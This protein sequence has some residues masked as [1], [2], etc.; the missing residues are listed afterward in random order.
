MVDITNLEN[1]DKETKLNRLRV[2]IF[3]ASVIVAVVLVVSYMHKPETPKE[4]NIKIEKL[5]AQ[6]AVFL[7]IIDIQNKELERCGF[8]RSVR[9]FKD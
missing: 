8:I 4:L 3:L 7:K 1:F 5:E 6:N 2:S 9:Y